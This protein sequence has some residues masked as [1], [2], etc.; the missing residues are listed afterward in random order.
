MNT[1][2]PS[3]VSPMDGEE[4]AWITGKL[5]YVQALPLRSLDQ[6]GYDYFAPPDFDSQHSC[7]HGT[8]CSERHADALR[9]FG[10]AVAV[11]SGIVVW[12]LIFAA[13][14]AVVEVLR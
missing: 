11:C 8:E 6:R 9:G 13:V 2:K 14:R 3:N 12:S 4:Y 10:V 7:L 5:W 1:V